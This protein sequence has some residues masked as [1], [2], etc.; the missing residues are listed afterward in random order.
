[1]TLS[2]HGQFVPGSGGSVPDIAPPQGVANQIPGLFVQSND[3][4]DSYF[5]GGTRPNL[6]LE[7]P[8]PSSHGASG[9]K[10]QR[11]P[12]TN[13]VWEDILQ[14]QTSDQDNFSFYPDG[15][16]SY[17]LLVQGGDK[18]G[19]VSNVVSAPV[20][21]VDTRFAGWGLDESM[22]ISGVMWPWVGRGLTARFTVRKLSDDS[23]VTDG[24][25]YQ[26]YRVNPMSGA[27]AAIPGAT[28]LTYIT[29]END[30][31]GYQLL[32]RGTGNET[33]VGGYAQVISSGPVLIPNDS[34][35][36]NLTA[37]G[38]Y[39]NLHKSVPSLTPGDLSL[40]YWVGIEEKSVT[41]TGVTASEGNAT[42]W[43]AAS[44][45]SGV[46][47]LT[48]DNNSDVW[49]LGSEVGPGHFMQSLQITVP[50]EG[51][52]PEIGVERSAGVA[53]TDGTGSQGFG[54]V[55]VGKTGQAASFT[56][57]NTGTANLTGLAI[58][59]KD[60]PHAADFQVSGPSAISVAPGGSATFTVAFKPTAAGTR[61]CAI[62]IAS[63]DADENP[64]DIALTGT[65]V[66]P[67]PDVDVQQPKGKS[68]VDNKN[69][70]SFGTVKIGG[71]GK[72]MVFTIKN[73]GTAAL[74][75]ISVKASGTHAKDFTVLAPSKTK[76]APGAS[77]TFRVT[78]KPKAK[79]IRK[80]ALK[81]RSN[82][83]DENPFDIV[84]KGK[85]SK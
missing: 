11:S 38:F 67:T 20:S 47:E 53:L 73:T 71:K 13:S 7:F 77:T 69:N 22:Y 60:G 26:W 35:A 70:R 41:I 9:Y 58:I 74:K 12:G 2:V 79:G 84:L 40:K 5:G 66:A 34:Y 65:G 10:L 44:M 85:G 24:M 14:T 46:T 45:P 82:D 55:L 62:H 15:S 49:G 1:M 16:Y 42:F 57:R 51:F 18:S 25:S 8:P 81:I 30:L 68:L 32:C 39:L 80:A 29:T 56:I 6:D 78:F 48:L 3:R 43:V 54:K 72:G 21:G 75:N 27:M 36:S 76:L 19:Y 83:P 31:G 23:E 59:T 52:A 4:S 17:R 50:T 64:F 63:N 61:T 33:T 28:E 37:H